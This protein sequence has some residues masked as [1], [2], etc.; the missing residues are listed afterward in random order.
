MAGTI[1]VAPSGRTAR[2]IN[3]SCGSV[4]K[5][6]RYAIETGRVTYAAFR[7]CSAIHARS[8]DSR[9]SPT[10][11]EV[12][13]GS[14]SEPR[15]GGVAAALGLLNANDS[16]AIR[17]IRSF[18]LEFFADSVA[19]QRFAHRGL[20]ADGS[21]LGVGFGRADDAIRLL[22]LDVL[23]EAH[24][25]AHAGPARALRRLDEDMVLDDGFELLDPGLHK[26]LL[27]LGRVVLEVL[28]EIAKL[29]GGLDLGD[30]GRAAH[31]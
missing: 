24:C 16:D 9:S 26:A 23:M 31:L 4:L 13:R 7:S 30:D 25:A 12:F 11:G 22:A 6:V 27:V 2:A 10:C 15:R 20:V 1:K 29:T 21:C 28:G 18:D 14:R 8:W 17:A 5:P 3:R 19:Q